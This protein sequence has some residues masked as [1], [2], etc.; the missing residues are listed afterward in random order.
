MEI[1]GSTYNNITYNYLD[2]N[3]PCFDERLDSMYNTF[4][5][6]TCLDEE[7]IIPGYDCFIILCVILIIPF[8]ILTHLWIKKLKIIH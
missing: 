3:G 4:K 6:N 8:L 7:G 2:G 5:G 1:S